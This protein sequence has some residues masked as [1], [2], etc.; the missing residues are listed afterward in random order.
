MSRIGVFLLGTM[1]AVTALAQ[2]PETN[3]VTGQIV[4]GPNQQ[5]ATTV[6]DLSDVI[7]EALEKNPGVQSALHTVNAQQ[8]K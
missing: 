1:L 4:T 8:H 3:L 2:E 6:L 5:E 7:R